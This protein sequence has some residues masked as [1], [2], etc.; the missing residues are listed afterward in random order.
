MWGQILDET[1]REFTYTA[2][3][4]DLKFFTSVGFDKVTFNWSGFNDKLPTFIDETMIRV[5]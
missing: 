3:Q 2:N 4:A 1:L 5:V